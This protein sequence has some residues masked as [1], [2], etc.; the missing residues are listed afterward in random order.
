V[1]A[2]DKTVLRLLLV[3]VDLSRSLADLTFVDFA[4]DRAGL[5]EIAL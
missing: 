3:K 2:K 4:N 1:V 5:G